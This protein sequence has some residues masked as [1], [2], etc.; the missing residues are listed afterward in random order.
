MLDFEG[1]SLEEALPEFTE[2]NIERYLSTRLVQGRPVVSKK[3]API[4]RRPI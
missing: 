3:N 4:A 2:A 1:A